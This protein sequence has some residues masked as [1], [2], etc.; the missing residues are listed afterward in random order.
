MNALATVRYVT[1]AAADGSWNMRA[2]L[3]GFWPGLNT[4]HQH[5]RDFGYKERLSFSDFWNMYR[6]NGYAFAAV[7]KTVGKTW[8][9]DPWLL[10]KQRDGSQGGKSKETRQEKLVRERFDEI[11][12]WSAMA[13]TDRRSLVGEYSAALLQIADGKRW[14]Q[15]VERV[16]SGLAGLVAVIP[17]WQ[18]Q[19]TVNEYYS[20]Q[21]DTETYG[22]PK[23]FTFNE[24]AFGG[25]KQ[26]RQ[27]TVH[28]DR[29]VIWS[30]DGTVNG[31]SKMEPGFNALMDL[32]KVRGAGGEGFWKTAKAS[33]VIEIPADGNIENFA[34]AMGV[35]AKEVLDLMGDQVD[36]FNRGYDN[37]LMMQGMTAKPM[38][39]SL[40]SPE[41][42]ARI[43]AE[44]FAASFSCP[45]KILLGSQSGERASTE[46][47]N[48]WAQ[49]NMS[50][51][52]KIAK[53][54]IRDVVRRL[55][56]FGILPDKPWVVDWSD[57][58]AMS[59]EAQ[60]ALA[61]KMADVNQKMKDSGEI[62]F[63]SDEIRAE[64]GREPL[65]DEQRYRTDPEDDE[66][67]MGGPDDVTEEEDQ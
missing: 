66:D 23:S 59:K 9:D 32:E 42:F 39:I 28:P 40:T 19:L 63:P 41:H 38:N 12:F 51:R 60:V 48:E 64:T 52:N 3:Q 13:E 11:N 2:G 56:K 44:E 10:E 65:T 25:A 54:R 45:L 53:P 57:L 33:P 49:T 35:T 20:D 43:P 62:V 1:N 16:S 24:Q 17:A 6:R 15:P 50:R 37:V 22:Q 29:V 8:Q 67:A 18:G 34:R 30:A 5:Y 27:F 36:R 58:T 55:V 61:D 4:K 26:P 31:E 14:D 7:E 46:D 47:A 21:N